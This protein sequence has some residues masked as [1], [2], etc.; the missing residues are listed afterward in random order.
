MFERWHPSLYNYKA[1][2]ESWQKRPTTTN[3]LG[4]LNLEFRR[5]TKNVGVFL[6]KQSLLRLVVTIVMDRNEE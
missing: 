1:Y 5:R 6:S 3:V 2:S 4:G